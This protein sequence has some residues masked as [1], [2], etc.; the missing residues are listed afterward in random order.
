M[1]KIDRVI[2]EKRSFEASGL[3]VTSAMEKRREMEKDKKEKKREEEKNIQEKIYKNEEKIKESI[4][5][6]FL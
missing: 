5:S 3:D 6:H 2:I 1:R 4:N